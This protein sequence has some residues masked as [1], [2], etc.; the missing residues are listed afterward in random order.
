[1]NHRCDEIAMTLEKIVEIQRRAV[2]EE[3]REEFCDFGRLTNGEGCGFIECNTRPIQLFLCCGGPERPWSLPID[4]EFDGCNIEGCEK[5]CVFRVE[6]VQNGTVTVRALK[7]K[8]E[9]KDHRERFEAT[10]S[11]EIIKLE[12]ITALR[13]LKDAFVDLCIRNH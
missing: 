11:F 3:R 8:H 7:E 6:R 5:S 10:D 4:R 12:N 9:C 2:R 1:M 13:C